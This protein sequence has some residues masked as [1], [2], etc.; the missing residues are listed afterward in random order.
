V[1]AEWQ[2]EVRALHAKATH[3]KTLAAAN[4]YRLRVA[5]RASAVAAAQR[6]ANDRPLSLGES[7]DPRVLRARI[8]H[9]ED[10][11]RDAVAAAA[12]ATNSPPDALL[13]RIAADVEGVL[14]TVDKAAGAVAGGRQVHAVSAALD[15][16]QQQEEQLLRLQ[17]LQQQQQPLFAPRGIVSS[18]LDS[19]FA[20]I[21][22]SVLLHQSRSSDVDDDDEMVV[23]QQRQQQERDV[24][25][26]YVVVGGGDGVDD[27]DGDHASPIQEH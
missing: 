2:A 5:L 19:S 18:A 24:G 10:A 9:L 16:S 3:Y 27:G 23:D 20:D 14:D 15:S 1:S 25:D 11:L 6:G 22:P 8:E 21:V 4:E 13:R 12:A 17:P 26:G 7:D